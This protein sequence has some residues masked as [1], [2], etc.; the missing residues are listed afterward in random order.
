MPTYEYECDGCGHRFEKFQSMKARAVR[1]CPKCSAL[2]VRRL[3]N[4][5]AAVIFKGSG[6]YATDYRSEEY[7][8]RASAEKS[9][10]ASSASGDGKSS[11]GPK[12]GK[13]S[14]R[15]GS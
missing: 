1:R 5:G 3:I 11:S 12:D 14:A 9:P 6:F 8:K 10:P 13:S 15:Q 2:K 7:R 4:A